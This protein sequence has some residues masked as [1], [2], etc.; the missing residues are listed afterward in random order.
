MTAEQWHRATFDGTRAGQARELARLT[1]DER[2]EL[3]EELLELAQA[4]GALA[5]S[6]AAKQQAV[7]ALWAGRAP[8][9]PP[10]S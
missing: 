9:D 5:R 3:L 6:R 1:P 7:D 2:V 4:S 8:A 10:H